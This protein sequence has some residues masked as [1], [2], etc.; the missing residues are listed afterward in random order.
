MLGRQANSSSFS[1]FCFK[2]EKSVAINWFG[3][4]T[5]IFS[6]AFKVSHLDRVVSS[7]RQSQYSVPKYGSTCGLQPASSAKPGSTPRA[8]S[9]PCWLSE[10][11]VASVG[12]KPPHK[13]HRCK[14]ASR[15]NNN[16]AT[17][18]APST[19]TCSAIGAAH[20]H[21]ETT[22]SRKRRQ[23]GP[24]CSTLSPSPCSE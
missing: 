18:P 24:H 16:L 2:I 11:V 22:T 3:G 8:S 7:I 15:V 6:M 10:V 20:Q 5:C 19:Q 17:H 21:E 1:T 9:S 13:A 14:S 4:G 23:D 12:S